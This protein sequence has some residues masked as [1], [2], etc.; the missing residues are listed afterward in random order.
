MNEIHT[1]VDAYIADANITAAVGTGPPAVAGDISVLA[2][3]NARISATAAAASIAVGVGQ[4]GIAISG[5]GAGATN[6]ILTSTDAYI[7][8]STILDA[9]D[10][11]VEATNASAIEATVAAVAAAVGGGQTGVGAAIGV[12]LARNLVGNRVNRA[13][14]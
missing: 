8:D 2:E 3:E 14:V 7:E 5:A 13:P 1:A 12:S 11:S 10:V 6:V 9:D 4:T